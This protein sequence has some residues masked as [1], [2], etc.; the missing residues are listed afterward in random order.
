MN[1]QENESKAVAEYLDYV[2][3]A[4]IQP[5]TVGTFLAG[6]RAGLA[7]GSPSW[8]KVGERLPSHPG[9]YDA[10]FAP[11]YTK[12]FVKAVKWDSQ[13]FHHGFDFE[14]VAWRER[15]E[16]YTDKDAEDL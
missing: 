14:P 5:D 6:Y 7:A 12:P 2:D 8:V 10:T 15:S 13:K 9:E 11:D 4:A 1:E 3:R 16:P